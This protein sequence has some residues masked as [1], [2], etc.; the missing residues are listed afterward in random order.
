MY[1]QTPKAESAHSSNGFSAVTKRR[2]LRRNL[3]QCR[4]ASDS[5]CRRNY[6]WRSDVYALQIL[7]GEATKKYS[8]KDP[9]LLIE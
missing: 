6:D 2:K 4:P 1:I 9:R 3:K 5:F 7:L 8:K